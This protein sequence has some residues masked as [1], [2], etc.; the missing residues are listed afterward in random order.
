MAHS[1]DINIPELLE[2]ILYFLAV[3]KSLYPALFVF[4]LW[5]RCDASFLW[6]RIELKGNDLKYGHHFPDDYTYHERDCTRCKRFIKLINEKHKPAYVLNTIHLE[7]TFYHSLSDKKIKSIVKMFPNIDAQAI[8]DKGLCAIIGLCRKLEHL[9]ISYCENISNKSLFEIA[10]NCRDLQEFHFAETCW[11][12]D[13]SISCIINSCPNLRN[14]D[15]AY[16]KGDVKDAKHLQIYILRHLEISHNDIGDEV[17]EALAYTCHKLEYLEL[18]G[19]S[20]VSELSIYLEG[21]ENISKKAMDQLNPNIHIE[22]FDKEYY[23]DSESSSSETKSECGAPILWRRI[24]LKGKDLYSEQS[25]PND[26]NYCVKH[27]SQLNKFIRIEHAKDLFRLKKF[28]KLVHRKQTPVYC[29][30]VTHL[31]ISYYHSLSDKKII[32]IIHS[33][34]NIIHLSFKNSV[35]FSNR[36]LELIAEVGD[37]GL[38]AIANSC[39]RLEY[40]NISNRIEYSETSICN[41]IRSC[42]RLQQLDLGFCQITDTTIEEIAKNFVDTITPPDLIG[43]LRNHLTQNNVASRQILAQSLQSFQSF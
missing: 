24:E 32:S 20:F 9:N 30:N 15:I 25:L 43:V 22:N 7:I 1:S 21:C 2:Q 26:Y 36:A 4:R 23:S 14:L 10:E 16:S 3:E 6:E 28:I 35:G 39:H 8:T 33:C 42:P 38:S 29:S 41:V 37:G 40:L 12:T 11:I 17:T 5:Y 13:K 34:P 18:S 31:E 27:H 19:Y